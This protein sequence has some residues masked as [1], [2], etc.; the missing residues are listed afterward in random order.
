MKKKK[1][2]VSL[3][4]LLGSATLTGSLLA[5]VK[6]DIHLRMT[7]YHKSISMHA[8]AISSG[9][10]KTK[11]EQ[12][13][14][15]REASTDLVNAR[16]THREMK[17]LIPKKTRKEFKP[18]HKSIDKM[19]ES[20][21]THINWLTKELTKIEPDYAKVKEHAKSLGDGIDKAEQEHLKLI[22]KANL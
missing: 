20:S 9:E 18:V 17:K 14:H 22:E 6:D 21:K 1:L 5:Q 13:K 19:Y 4:I 11:E 2:I 12:L 3:L 15:I 8:R 10:A 16:K 7:N